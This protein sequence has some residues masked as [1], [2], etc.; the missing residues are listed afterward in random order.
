[1]NLDAD[2]SAAVDRVV[3]PFVLALIE[4]VLA[5]AGR[6]EGHE[7]LGLVLGLL[8][9]GSFGRR[10]FGSLLRSR[11]SFLGAG[12]RGGEAGKC[13]QREESGVLHGKDCCRRME[14]DR[15]SSVNR[16]LRDFNI[17]PSG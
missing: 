7:P 9:G 1:D 6:I 17:L 8:G 14:G 13:E 10:L 12:Q 3:V 11:I 5:G 15:T 4:V 2:R 16:G